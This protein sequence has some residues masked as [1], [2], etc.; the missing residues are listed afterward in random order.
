VDPVRATHKGIVA[1][2]RNPKISHRVDGCKTTADVPDSS[3]APVMSVQVFPH[4]RSSIRAA[5]YLSLF[6]SSCLM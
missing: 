2:I 3:T 6:V 5:N 1:T 4:R